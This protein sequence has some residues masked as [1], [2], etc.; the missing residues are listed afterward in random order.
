MLLYE[1]NCGN[2][3]GPDTSDSYRIWDELNDTVILRNT[4]AGGGV[5]FLRITT[6]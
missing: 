1:V 6:G 3:I 4:L 2:A 5:S